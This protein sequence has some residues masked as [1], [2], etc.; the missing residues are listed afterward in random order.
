GGTMRNAYYTNIP[1]GDYRFHVRASNNDGVWNETGAAL[2][3]R[4]APH[5]Y[6]TR[7]F[8]LVYVLAAALLVALGF[9]FHRV[10][11]RQL[12]ARERELLTLVSERQRAEAALKAANAA[13]EERAAELARSN[14]ELERFAY[15][16]SHDLKEP[17]RSV[18]SFTQLLE[19][20]YKGRLDA[21]ADSYIQF[22]VD[23]AKSMRRLIE[24]LLDYAR[25]ASAE[26]TS[27]ATSADDALRQALENLRAAVEHSG[28]V[29]T[30]AP[31]PD[32]QARPTELVQLFQNLID[33]A[34]KFRSD[35]PPRIH[36]SAQREKDAP[37][38][39]FCV[40]DNGI[41][42]EP[43][44]ADKVFRLFQ[45]LHNR[46]DYPGTGIGLAVCKKIVESAGGRIWVE[47]GDGPG[48]RI[49]FTLPA[50]PARAESRPAETQAEAAP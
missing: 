36:L 43:R 42:I 44:Y 39:R 10:R 28:A 12:Q 38:W 40:A 17:L 47:A 45:R 6:E 21:E 46:E 35:A 41:G 11:V 37:L 3:F 48:A 19:K 8:Y 9:R 34:I 18:I 31:L 25:I 1:P 29:V 16:A 4:L 23:G 2:D 30:H 26:R 24:N 13:L 20:K 32:V 5:F 14:A 22:A 33:N 15:V 7:A 49:A 27:A 50:A